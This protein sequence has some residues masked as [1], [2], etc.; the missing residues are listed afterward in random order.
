MVCGLLDVSVNPCDNFY[1]HICSNWNKEDVE[2]DFDTTDAD[3]LLSRS[4]EASA[5]AFLDGTFG[6]P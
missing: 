3:D 4:T 2:D 5:K 1:N 6:V